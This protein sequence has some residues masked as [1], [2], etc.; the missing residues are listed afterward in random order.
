MNPVR[1]AL[2]LASDLSAPVVRTGRTLAR[3]AWRLGKD[4]SARAVTQYHRALLTVT[5]GRVG[6]SGFGMPVLELSTTGRKSGKP[7]TIVLT[8]PVQE[9]DALVVVASYGGDDR[10]PAWYLNLRDDPTVEVK[11]RGVT[12]P[13]VARVATPDERT[14]LWPQVTE[15]YRGYASYQERTDREIPLVILEP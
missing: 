3:P 5:R 15:K 4:L 11:V 1:G 9:G 10:H 7:R 12:R 8:S 14:R 6:N 2:K 13:M